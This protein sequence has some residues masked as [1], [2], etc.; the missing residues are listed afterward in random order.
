[1]FLLL[2]VNVV[3]GIR[4]SLAQKTTA[5]MNRMRLQDAVLR[6]HSLYA[7]GF[8]RG[9]PG[10]SEWKSRKGALRLRADHLDPR[11]LFGVDALNNST[12]SL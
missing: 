11:Y 8:V 4:F 5:T 3:G 12:N 1:M 2:A 6:A 7:D 10:Q 9:F